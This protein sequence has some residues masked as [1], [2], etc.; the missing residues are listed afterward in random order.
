MTQLLHPL[1]AQAFTT[2]DQAEVCWCL[3]RVPSNPS[4]PSGDIDLLV[5][6]AQLDRLPGLLGPLGFVALPGWDYGSDRLFLAY[7]QETGQWI[8]LDVTDQVTFGRNRDLRTTLAAGCLDRRQ[9]LG[10]M[11]APSDDDAFWL[12]LLHCLLDKQ[13]VPAHYRERLVDLAGRALVDGPFGRLAQR[14]CP[15]GWTAGRL[16]EVS[17]SGDWSTLETLTTQISAS[18]QRQLSPPERARSLMQR[19]TRWLR[20]PLLLRQ[21]RGISVALMGANGAGKSTLAQGLKDSFC[22]PVA[23]VYMGLWASG[24]APPR[25]TIPG[26]DIALRPVRV[27]GRYLLALSHQARGHLVV[28]DRYTYDALQTPQP[29]LVQLK[30]PYFWL[31]AHTCPPPDLVLVLDVP[32]TVSFARKGEYPEAEL[33]EERVSYLALR[34]RLPQL[35]VLDATQSR[36]RLRADAMERIWKQYRARWQQ[37]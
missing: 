2:L 8:W 11:W 14:I 24:D 29:P 37:G 17:R 15:D 13:T 35:Q 30:R 18:W 12:L 6:P 31:L 7:D 25:R 20:K 1:L 36:E 10:E 33:E 34:S 23:S 26:L 16:L 4:A 28:F 27:W 19:T 22:M 9:R 3:L 21:R 5:A 32:G